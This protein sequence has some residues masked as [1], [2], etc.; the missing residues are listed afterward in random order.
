MYVLM[1][2]VQLSYKQVSLT[3]G[4]LQGQIQ[5]GLGGPPPPPHLI[6]NTNCPESWTPFFCENSAGPSLPFKFLD[7]PLS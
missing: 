3:G 2:K 4:K 6:S 1:K 5:G 7:L